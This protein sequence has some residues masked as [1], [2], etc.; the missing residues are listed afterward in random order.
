[1]T[2]CNCSRAGRRDRQ[3]RAH[4]RGVVR[5]LAQYGTELPVEAIGEGPDGAQQQPQVAARAG[6]E[7]RI[8]AHD[9]T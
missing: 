2:N 3:E 9:G 1:V 8:V 5:T 6:S 4:L 7:K